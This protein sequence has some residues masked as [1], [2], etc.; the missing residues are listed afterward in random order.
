MRPLEDG[1]LSGSFVVRHREI[2]R[3]MFGADALRAALDALSPEASAAIASASKVGWVPVE[4][5]EELFE[6]VAKQHGR[7]PK[8]L[9]VELS[10]RSTEH[11]VRSVWRLLLQVTTDAQLVSQTPVFYRRAWN[12]GALTARLIKPGF[13]IMTLSSWPGVPDFTVRGL[14]TSVGRVLEL[15]GRNDV[16]IVHERTDDGASYEATW[17]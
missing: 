11:T 16:R 5:V 6:V 4:A 2:L 17:S 3:E 14:L 10:R 9:H 1:A 12:R 7:D 8:E 15:A 13:A